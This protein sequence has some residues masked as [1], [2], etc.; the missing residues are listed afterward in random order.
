MD[1]EHF[2]RVEPEC[3]GGKQCTRVSHRE[4]DH[5][6]PLLDLVES[7]IHHPEMLDFEPDAVTG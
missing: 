2:Q 5:E 1:K 7:I 4:Q 3:S 6:E